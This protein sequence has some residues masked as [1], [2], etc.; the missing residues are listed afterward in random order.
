MIL[1]PMKGRPDRGTDA[2]SAGS[3]SRIQTPLPAWLARASMALLASCALVLTARSEPRIPGLASGTLDPELRGQILIEELNCVACHEAEGSLKAR[4]KQAPR[5]SDA[6]SR[7]NPNFLERFIAD[8]HGTQVGTTMPDVLSALGPEERR[9]TAQALTHF[10]LSLGNNPFSLTPPDAV[11]AEHGQRL[12][13]SRGCVA[14]HPTPEGATSGP[15]TRSSVPLVALESKYNFQSLSGFL[16]EPHQIRPSGRMPNLRLNPQDAERITHYLLKS[17]RVPGALAYTRY[18]GQVWEGL[19]SEEVRAEQAGQVHDFSLKSLGEV[20]HH[21]AIRYEGWMKIPARGT[22]RFFL[23]MNGG[24][25][26]V[27]GHPLVQ[28]EPSDNRGVLEWTPELA[29]EPGWRAIQLTYFHTGHDPVFAFEMEGPEF[30]RKPLPGSMLSV[31]RDPIPALEPFQVDPSLAA[32]GR[33]AF[34][35]HG[36][37]RCHDDLQIESDPGTN[38]TQLRPGHGCL[39]GE[40]GPWPRFD[41]DP[42]QRA[43]MAQALARVGQPE[44]SDTQRIQKT[45]VTF[46]CIACHERTGVGGVAPERLGYFTGTEPGL[47]DAG[48]LP[49]TLNQVGAKLTPEGFRDVLLHGKRPRRYLDA[50]MPQYGEAQVGHLVDLFARVDR[51]EAAQIPAVT[52]ATA[53]RRA[54]HELVG[55]EGF[56]CIACHAF[57]GQKSGEMGAVDLAIVSRRLQKNWFH[58]Y[59]REPARFSPTVIMPSY[60]PNGRSGRTNLLDGDATQE[61]EALWVYLDDGERAKKPIG[62]S[63]RSRELRVGDMTELCR[64]QSPVG[65]RGIGIGYPER[66]NLAFDSGEMALRL[67]WK[68]EFVSIDAGHFHPRGTDQISFPPGVPFH[69]LESP[70][71]SWPRKGKKNHLFPQD[72]GYQFLGYRLDAQRRPTLRYRYGD[73]LVEDFFED[74]LDPESKPYFRRTLTFT[75]PSASQ[76]F[77]FR[78]AVDP[79]LTTQ[80]DRTFDAGPLRLRITSDHAGRV[81]KGRADE[82]LIP[83]NPP[84]GRS[85]LT[86]EYQW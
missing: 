63:R 32:K 4:S 86:L 78:A 61:I 50:S 67:L 46:N 85:T 69:R 13:L 43:E 57:N 53:F 52:N 59:L 3:G 81:R 51:L 34:A 35:R 84:L 7:L 17:T 40:V 18:Q 20:G 22:Y 62:L 1:L 79:R 66:I 75:A 30:P 5:L 64:G 76:P 31:S 33:Q 41:L 49:P 45:L 56:S 11:A 37:A 16:Q 24:S 47:G 65:Y 55:S 54:G 36:C 38:W 25:L 6:G 44:L 71:A 42:G 14:C 28:Q 70:E 27:D 2:T 10:L 15:L 80:S 73:I 48:R 8:P 68:G 19:A 74:L 39:G 21:T 83:L 12:F 60:W 26:T 77:E 23:R 82:L 29:L 9:A 58:L 72:H